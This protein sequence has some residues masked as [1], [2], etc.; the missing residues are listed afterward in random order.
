M[1]L[2]IGD[3][4]WTTYND[5]VNNG[6]LCATLSSATCP[7]MQLEGNCLIAFLRDDPGSLLRR[8]HI[9]IR[10]EHLRPFARENAGG[11]RPNSR[12]TTRH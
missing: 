11:F 9:H 8:I 4:A 2:W 5:M 3:E 6:N 10:A 12:G 1:K 7:D